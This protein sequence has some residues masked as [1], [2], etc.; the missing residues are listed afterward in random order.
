MQSADMRP[1]EVK[2][3]YKVMGVP[4]RI[5]AESLSSSNRYVD[6][7]MPFREK[8]AKFQLFV[9]SKLSA[10]VEMKSEANVCAWAEGGLL[11]IQARELSAAIATLAEVIHGSRLP[12][13]EAD[14]FLHESRALGLLAR[15]PLW[16]MSEFARELSLTPSTA[17]H[18]ADRLLRKHAVKR[19]RS[20]H[21]RRLV[22][23]SLNERRVRRHE[24]LFQSQV[25]ICSALLEQLSPAERETTCL[26]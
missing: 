17:S 9:P 25:R 14:T 23:I 11:G 8:I 13:S 1:Y 24:A 6:S 7:R 3:P 20:L 15:K 26:P 22:L 19:A 5:P 10:S 16:S 18:T 12:G 4:N 2:W 21:D